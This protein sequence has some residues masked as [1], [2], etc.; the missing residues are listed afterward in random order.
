[1][2]IKKKEAVQQVYEIHTM[3]SFEESL[4]VIWVWNCI[5]HDKGLFIVANHLMF[6]VI[7][8]GGY[9]HYVV[10]RASYSHGVAQCPVTDEWWNWE[11][12]QSLSTKS[13]I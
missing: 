7:P 10:S 9:Y 8:G 6:L 3:K 12:N 2:L 11:H 13:H 1:M 4:Y 5:S